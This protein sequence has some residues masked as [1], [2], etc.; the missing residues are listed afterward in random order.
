MEDGEE[1]DGVE[2]EGKEEEEEERVEANWGGEGK[3]MATGSS[4]N[5]YRPFI[6]PSY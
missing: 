5:D 6:L 3:A 2:E 4:G 1:E